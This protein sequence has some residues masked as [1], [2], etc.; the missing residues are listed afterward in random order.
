MEGNASREDSLLRAQAS[1]ESFF[2]AGLWHIWHPRAKEA[3]KLTALLDLLTIITRLE[4]SSQ[5]EFLPRGAG[6]SE[7][8]RPALNAYVPAGLYLF[9]RL[10]HGFLVP[11]FGDLSPVL[12]TPR[13][14]H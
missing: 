9:P 4:Y 7:Y 13:H 3:A 6:R 14:V 1:G 8:S 11:A 2:F 12:K 10:L 5:G